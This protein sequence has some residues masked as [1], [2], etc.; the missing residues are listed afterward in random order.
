MV[1]LPIM[2]P[3]PLPHLSR[4]THR[5]RRGSR[6]PPGRR[7][8]SALARLRRPLALSHQTPQVW[9]MDSLRLRRLR[10]PTT[11][12]FRRP[13]HRLTTGR[14]HQPHRCPTTARFHR[15]HLIPASVK[16]HS[17]HRLPTSAR[18]PRPRLLRL[19]ARCL[20]SQT[21]GTFPLPRLSPCH[22]HRVI[23]CPTLSALLLV[24]CPRWP[25]SGSGHMASSSTGAPW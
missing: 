15:L 8:P 17:L 25:P 5:L 4:G 24:P 21:R 3:H 16:L 9:A 6:P 12:R 13:Q 2:T 22:Q 23:S 1:L 20:V 18:S 11:A 14:F 19:S 7:P 10:R